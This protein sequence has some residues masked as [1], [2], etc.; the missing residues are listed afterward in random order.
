MDFMKKSNSFLCWIMSG[1][2]NSKPLL[3]RGGLSGAEPVKS[4]VAVSLVLWLTFVMEKI[5][6]QMHN[7][8]I[9]FY[10]GVTMSPRPRKPRICCPSRR[11]NERLFKPACTPLTDLEQVTLEADEFES[12]SLCDHEGMTQAQAGLQ[13]GIS[14]GTVQRLVT[15]GRRKVIAALLEGNALVIQVDE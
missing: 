2:G 1:H 5:N 13:M 14:R 11:P 3:A 4:V 7:T 10:L 6:V 8:C 12:L 9:C 15:S